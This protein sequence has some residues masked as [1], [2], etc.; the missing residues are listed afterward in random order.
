M[1]TEISQ[2]LTELRKHIPKHVTLVAVSKTYPPEILM[3]AY[4]AGQRIFGENKV[5][6]LFQK[7]SVMPNDIEWHLIGHLQ[8]NKVKY[9]A[10]FVKLIH[11]IDSLKLLINT[12]KEAL[13]NNRMIDCLLQFHIGAEVTKFGLNLQEAEALLNAPEY[14]SLKNTRITGVMGMATFTDNQQQIRTEF[15]QLHDIFHHLKT[16][17]FSDRQHFKEISMGMSDDYHIAIEEG[18]TIVRIGSVIFG[19]RERI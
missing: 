4:Q 13:K 6:E 12:N 19:R 16:K 15:Q 8:S 10:P 9:I 17:Y 14:K 7:Q 11:S 1:N 3:K 2:N 5:Q 18:A